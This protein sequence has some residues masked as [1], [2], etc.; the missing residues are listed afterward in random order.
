MLNMQDIKLLE[1]ISSKDL[2]IFSIFLKTDRKSEPFDKVRITLKNLLKKQERYFK[3]HAEK[4][5]FKKTS[6]KITEYVE[7]MIPQT[8]LHGVAIFAGGDDNIFETVELT[9]IPTT[10]QNN[11]VLD[12]KPFLDVFDFYNKKFKKFAL[13]VS[14]ERNSKLFLAQG[15]DIIEVKDYVLDIERRTDREGIFR[16]KRGVSGGGNPENL[17]EKEMDLKR[18]FKGITA[19]LSKICQT[20]NVEALL[21]S[22]SAK[23]LPIIEKEI[24]KVLQKNILAKW[25]EN[26]TK[27][28]EVKL[29]NKIKDFEK[30][31]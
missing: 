30:N 21:L 13:I 14:D 1:K 17:D 28:D 23:T 3:S 6:E 15:N 4:A 7:Q 16:S 25:S 27:T 11:V 5:Y 2:P 26:L 29:L 12:K 22:A 24:P 8:R 19:D 31:L 10:I 9:L 18:Y 20:E